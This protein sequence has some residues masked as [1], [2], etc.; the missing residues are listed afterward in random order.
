V[1]N[2]RYTEWKNI[3]RRTTA[4][5]LACCMMIAVV[6]SATAADA[7][8]TFKA[9]IIGG[10][11][12][13]GATVAVAVYLEPGT[14]SF[15]D[16]AFVGYVL[17]IAYDPD[18][19]SIEDETAVV[20]EAA[21]EMYDV[22]VDAVAGSVH[23]EAAFFGDM[24]YVEER[25][26]MLTIHFAINP[27]AVNGN[28]DV[29]IQAGTFTYDVN[30]SD[31][32]VFVPGVISVTNDAPVASAVSITGSAA[33]GMPL[34]GSYAYADT[35]NN[36]EGSS[37]LQ[38]YTATDAQGT[39]KSA[40]AEATA[41]AFTPDAALA[42]QYLIFGVTPVAATGTI[43][44][45]E[46]LSAAVGPVTVGV[47]HTAEVTIGK[48]NGTQ[49][50]SV[51]V[52]VTLTSASTGIGSY[53]IRIDYD[54]S[55]LEVTGMTG[56]T[57]DDFASHYS[58]TDGWLH[59]AWADASGGDHPI[60]Q[61]QKLFTIQFAVKS[62]S[63][64]GS[65]SL[66]VSTDEPSHYTITDIDA[67]EL[68]KTVI[69]GE[70]IVAAP[71]SSNSDSSTGP[72][73][74]LVTVNVE[75]PGSGTGNVISTAVIERTAK[76]DGTK[77]DTVVFNADQVKTTI[78]NLEGADSRA[79]YIVFPDTK[80]EV[81]EI[82]VTV[83]KDAGKLLYDAG[84]EL[85]LVTDNVKILI[86][87]DS[88][89]DFTEDLYFRIVPLKS[90]AAQQEVNE[91]ANRE[92]V[93]TTATGDQGV[94][95]V[96]RPMTIETNL[97]SRPVTLVLPIKGAELSALERNYLGVYIEHSDGTR[98]LLQGEIVAYDNNGGLGLQFSVNKFSTFTLVQMPIP[99]A[100]MI[101]YEDGFFRP[102]SHVTRAE[103]AMML[104]RTVAKSQGSTERAYS[105][106]PVGHW[107][108]EAIAAASFA[109]FM[110]GYP[111][112]SFAPGKAISR[113]EMAS[114]AA[115]LIKDRDAS[116]PGTGFEDVKGHWAEEAIRRVQAAGI[117]HGYEN[118][119]FRP[120]QPVTRAEAAAML[121]KALGRKPLEGILQSPWLDVKTTH[122]AYGDIMAATLTAEAANE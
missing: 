28:T 41:A 60:A 34:T 57:G 79:A 122:W 91:R 83:P 81:S 80:D 116:S 97:Q 49:G 36:A 111:E 35:E 117:I 118:G 18:V 95:V 55:A 113:A 72:A 39:D 12:Q 75:S 14:I 70:V 100:Y 11:G 19:L 51:Q 64:L 31:I 89:R 47:L 62:S 93:V 121:N 114:L 92:I 73:K 56:H 59:A 82:E 21:S 54:A 45:V 17:D 76:S 38:W 105:D 13:A 98:E 67:V 50:Q 48:V 30:P 6:T 101:G 9:E 104:S 1:G 46:A 15:Y 8:S 94:S 65:T 102:D 22:N 96:G 25:Q 42:G 63:S 119:A 85:G 68:S 69:D 77:K 3:L 71:S 29:T 7:P 74:E 103:I 86:P 66:A 24:Y 107:A 90:E 61:G 5:L 120:E 106:V 88:L 4:A 33:V 110:R 43:T 26:K 10:A 32:L 16:D 37:V 2:L 78:G 20:D 23:V 84:I 112:G 108:A 115:V 44:G 58:N 99:T 52:P 53:G 27:D 40:I 87:N 109:G